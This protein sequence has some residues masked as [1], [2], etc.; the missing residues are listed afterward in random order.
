VTVWL[1]DAPA[2]GHSVRGITLEFSAAQR[3]AKLCLGAGQATVAV[4]QEADLVFADTGLES[5]YRRIG[6][7]WQASRARNVFV[8][9]EQPWEQRAA[10]VAL[11]WALRDNASVCVPPEPGRREGRCGSIFATDCA[12]ACRKGAL[13]E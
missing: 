12:D 10:N 8:A 3:A 11:D 4:I 6:G 1:W 5:C 13:H 9:W 7:C 2:P